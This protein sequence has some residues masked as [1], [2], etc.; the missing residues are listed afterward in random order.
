M[1][2]RSATNPVAAA[3]ESRC[4]SSDKVMPLVDTITVLPAFVRT[5]TVRFTRLAKTGWRPRMRAGGVRL[6]YPAA[7]AAV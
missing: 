3:S 4:A 7:E 5:A 6:G 2:A 1:S